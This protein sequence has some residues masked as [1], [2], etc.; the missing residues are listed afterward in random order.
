[1]STMTGHLEVA[2]ARRR[3]TDCR[4]RLVLHLDQ[5]QRG[6]PFDVSVVE[7]VIVQTE[8]AVRALARAEEQAR[9]EVTV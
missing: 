9:H 5:I 2:D 7:Q 4:A 3:F 8:V 6:E 1:M